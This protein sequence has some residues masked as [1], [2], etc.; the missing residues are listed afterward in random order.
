MEEDLGAGKSTGSAQNS[1]TP[2]IE[3]RLIAEEKA[4]HESAEFKFRLF[5]RQ[6]GNER[7]K[8]CGAAGL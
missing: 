7:G 6:I 3:R 5:G 2:A 8:L 1:A 4:E